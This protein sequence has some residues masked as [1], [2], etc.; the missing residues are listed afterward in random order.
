MILGCF[1]LDGFP[2]LV[3]AIQMGCTQRGS[4][5]Q[6]PESLRTKESTIFAKRKKIIEKRFYNAVLYGVITPMVVLALIF[7]VMTI[8]T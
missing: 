8:H 2:L 3:P 5:L 7:F 6:Y 4:G 1:S